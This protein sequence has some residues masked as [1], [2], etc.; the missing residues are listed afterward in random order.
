MCIQLNIFLSLELN[1]FL[2]APMYSYLLFNGLSHSIMLILKEK[3]Y[4]SVLSLVVLIA[5]I[6][7]V[8]VDIKIKADR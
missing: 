7:S 6:S 1:P 3:I 5:L 2:L 4:F 8:K